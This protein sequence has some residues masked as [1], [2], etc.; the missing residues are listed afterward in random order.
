MSERERNEA[1]GKGAA[2]ENN[3]TDYVSDSNRRVN[4]S[5]MNYDLEMECLRHM[6][7]H[8][9][10]FEG[11]LQADDKIHRFSI[12]GKLSKK[13]AWYI[14]KTWQFRGAWYFICY[15]GAWNLDRK[16]TFCSW[17]DHEKFSIEEQREFDRYVKEMER[18]A[19][20]E[21]KARQDEAA[22]EAEEI[23]KQASKEPT[24]K[25]HITYLQLKK[26]EAYNVRFGKTPSRHPAIILP[27]WN[28]QGK[29][30][31]L[32]FISVNQLTGSVYKS[33]LTGGE[34]RG[35]FF[36]IGNLKNTA[37]FLVSEG[38][39]TAATV[40]QADGRPVVIAF[41]CGN[42]DS[43]IASLRIKYPKHEI[44][45]AGDDDVEVKENPG[46]TKAEAAA[47]KYNC[48]I[49]FP[50][51]STDLKLSNGKR[52]T[53]FNDLNSLIGI[54]TVRDQ[55]KEASLS[56]Q[57]PIDCVTDKT[58]TTSITFDSFGDWKDPVDFQ[59]K[60]LPVPL[61]DPLVLPEAL[62][63]HAEDAADRMQCPIDFI[64]VAQI[65]VFSSLI[66]AGC[67]IRPKQLDT[68]TVIPNE[69]GGIVSPP[70]GMKTAALNEG[71]SPLGELEKI[72]D[73]NYKKEEK[74]NKANR[75]EV[76]LR[77]LL[78]EANIKEAIKNENTPAI[79]LYKTALCALEE[80]SSGVPWKRY[81]TNDGTIEKITEILRDNPRGLLVYRDEL[82]GFLVLLD[83]EGREAD[84][85]FY[86]ESWNGY[87]SSSVK[88]DRI[89]RG[90]ISC[91]P[92]ISILGGIQP[93]KL[94]RYLFD[95]VNDISNDGLLQRF[96]IMVYPDPLKQFKLVDRKP[97]YKAR[98]RVFKIAEKIA[99]TDFIAM[100]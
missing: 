40:H 76:R 34:K 58:D 64:A 87:A 60:L 81:K 36:V 7:E 1:A 86:L 3:Q 70:S 23:W 6:R 89:G 15:Y 59:D 100:G 2:I 22:L 93:S 56:V 42:F 47:D 45:I 61:L 44:I 55:L 74:K 19:E 78:I 95:A 99:E 63:Y 98:E 25:G 12:G 51:F 94:R 29:I 39:S 48:K 84:R 37:S 72:A 4:N 27:L 68:W 52:P 49:I 10:P 69:W 30:R 43:V 17:K 67:C 65:V 16:E 91:N 66:G 77:K 32:Q 11:P 57:C 82:I 90:T 41:D 54:D 5:S 31:S 24:E 75:I 38:F 80:E 8:E 85:A 46:R 13:D 21:L 20:E 26:I 53:D 50:K 35:C 62:R 83:K 92:C 71:L 14:A 79:E 18:I 96:Q 33:F 9:I 88:S 28:I 73:E 97:N